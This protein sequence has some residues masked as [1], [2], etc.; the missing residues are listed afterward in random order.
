MK[1]SKIF[2]L[3]MG[4][5]LALTACGGSVGG[6]LPVSESTDYGVQPQATLSVFDNSFAMAPEES[7]FTFYKKLATGD[8]MRMNRNSEE[9]DR[10]GYGQ[11]VGIGFE[12]GN[13]FVARLA[14]SGAEILRCDAKGENPEVIFST[15]RKIRQ[16]LI[17]DRLIYF[18]AYDET[19]SDLWRCN[20]KGKSLSTVSSSDHFVGDYTLCADTVYYGMAWAEELGDYSTYRCG[21]SGEG[22]VL[23]RFRRGGSFFFAG[24][25][26][27]SAVPYGEN[28]LLLESLDRESE[29]DSPCLLETASS[30][31]SALWFAEDVLYFAPSD[32]RMLCR[33]HLTNRT[34][35]ELVPEQE[36]A[37]FTGLS[38]ADGRLF[39]CDGDGK[40]YV[41]SAEK[42]WQLTPIS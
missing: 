11:V 10:L 8:L 38:M 31:V 2:C 42:D 24:E 33:I 14:E 17:V 12:D 39:V 41:T 6:D 35:E 27:Y 5:L 40:Q 21:I 3:L 26:L 32:S 22:N 4:I 28:V 36:G 25:E 29:A 20:L 9:A 16:M 18:V 13:L 15:E 7:D 37:V 23:T 34:V 19:A 1:K 30:M